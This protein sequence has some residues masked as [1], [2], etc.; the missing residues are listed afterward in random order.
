MLLPR[1]MTPTSTSEGRS[2]HSCAPPEPRAT[3]R[4]QAFPDADDASSLPAL[5][6]LLRLEHSSANATGCPPPPRQLGK[7]RDGSRPRARL[8]LRPAC[9]LAIERT[10]LSLCGSEAGLCDPRAI[11][12]PRRGT[13]SGAAEGQLCRRLGGV[14]VYEGLER[15]RRRASRNQERNADARRGARR[16][17]TE[18]CS[19]QAA[20]LFTSCVRNRRQRP[21]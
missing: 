11:P 17:G 19:V 14:S 1:D 13:T 4:I 10:L 20:L 5:A 15:R 9:Q 18:R 3:D 7:P 2:L 8:V 21:R 16:S 6:H 12:S